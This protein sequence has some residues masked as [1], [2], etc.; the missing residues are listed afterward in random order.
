MDLF[1]NP[2]IYG[3]IKTWILHPLIPKLNILHGFTCWNIEHGSFI[4]TN[5]PNF[6]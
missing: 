4:T 3:Y 1:S 2:E 5:V 6:N